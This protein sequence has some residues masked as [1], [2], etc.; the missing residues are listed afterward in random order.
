MGLKYKF[1]SADAASITVEDED[2]VIKGYASIFGNKDLG[3]DIVKK[4]AFAKSLRVG[5]TVKMFWNH[6]AKSVPI[7]V[8]TL[9]KEDDKGLYVEGKLF[10]DTARGREVYVALKNGA[11]DGLSIG[12][13]TVRAKNTR[14]GFEISELKLMEVSVVNFPMNEAA[15]VESVKSVKTVAEKK[16]YLE[17]H[18]RDAGFTKEQAMHGASVLVEVVLSERDA[19]NTAI[20]MMEELKRFTRDLLAA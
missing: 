20:V 3:G 15:T 7:G 19:D 5:Q 10:T 8:W 16:R 4:G 9:V 1:I 13:K 11:I 17:K 12:Y 6:D 14:A 18:L 2:G